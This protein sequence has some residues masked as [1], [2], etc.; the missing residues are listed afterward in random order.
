M[1]NWRHL[2]PMAALR[3]FA[4]YAETGNVSKA[5][6]RLNVSHAAISQQIRALETHLAITLL[7]RSNRSAA[8]TEAGERLAQALRQGFGAI[9]G[10][11]EELT[12]AEASRPVHVS[13]TP[14][15]A[16]TWFMPRLA[17]FRAAHPE[18]NLMID[19]SPDVRVLEP[20]GLDVA[21][22]YGNGGWE[23]LDS[24]LLLPSPVAVVAAPALVGDRE[25]AGPK[26][27]GHFHWLQ[28]LGVNEAS[29]WFA[30]YGVA[31]NVE[32]GVTE[33]PGNLLL[34]AARAGQGVAIVARAT[35]EED[36]AADRLRLLFQDDEGKGYHIVT[37]PGVQRAPVRM[38]LRWL[39]SQRN[40]N[41][42]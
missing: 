4:A 15:F 41:A 37:R 31:W 23:G 38:L 8:L 16:S 26:E 35:V 24:D 25:I 7:D 32:G 29:E 5:G 2:P 20:G 27:L 1:I 9:A 39:R 6:V 11:V 21:I 14:T 12:G 30:R 22:R 42:K 19:P 17:N 10:A 36:I 3:A 33:L 18:I 34:E 28:E 40:E 13:M